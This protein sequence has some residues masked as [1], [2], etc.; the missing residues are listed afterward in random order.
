MS[1]A[2][3]PINLKV[4]GHDELIHGR[5]PGEPV[6]GMRNPKP[7]RVPTVR[8]KKN[9]FNSDLYIHA[10]ILWPALGF[11]EVIAPQANATGG[12]DPTRCIHLLIIC[13]SK[14][15]YPADVARHLRWVPWGER[16]TRHSP[17]AENGGGNAFANGEIGVY[18]PAVSSSKG[19]IDVV[20]FADDLGSGSGIQVGLSKF[21]LNFYKGGY[22]AI[23]GKKVKL[24][25]LHHVKISESASAQL[26]AG[27][28][29]NLFWIN[30]DEKDTANERSA[31]M[32]PLIDK[33]AKNS[34]FGKDGVPTYETFTKGGKEHPYATGLLGEYEYDFR[35]TTDAANRT[36]V[37][38]PL[39]VREAPAEL[40]IGHLTD[41]HYC[42]R[43]D[44]YEHN[45]KRA[46]I[47][48]ATYNEFNNWNRTCNKLYSMAK[49]TNDVLL[50][51]GDLIDY[52]RGVGDFVS[53]DGGA[54][55][56]WDDAYWRDRNWF[57]FYD[58]IANGTN[59]EKPVYTILGNHD[60]RF[61]PYAPSSP[62]APDPEAMNLT[63]K[64]VEI[65]HGPG[66]NAGRM[67]PAEGIDKVFAYLGNKLLPW[68]RNGRLEI[69]GT[70][71]HTVIDSVAW[72]LLLINPFLDYS[73]SIPGGYD[74]LM[75]DW[76]ED[77]N[78]DKPQYNKGVD[79]GRTIVLPNVVGSPNAMKSLSQEQKDIVEHFVEGKGRAKFFGVHAAVVGPWGH[80]Y[81][82][83]LAR[84]VVVLPHN[85]KL[86][87]GRHSP[88]A[89]EGV[90][91]KSGP[92]RFTEHPALAVR[93]K[94]YEPFAQVAN[95]GTMDEKREWLIQ[96]L[97]QAGVQL[98]FSGH[99][100]RRTLLTLE[101][102]SDGALIVQFIDDGEISKAS[103]LPV[104]VNSTSAGPRGQIRPY[105]DGSQLLESAFAEVKL[106]AGGKIVDITHRT[107]SSPST[108]PAT[109]LKKPAPAPP[110]TPAPSPAPMKVPR[111][112]F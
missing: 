47:R 94:D 51:T 98:V 78:V 27:A 90:P 44:R 67:Y 35:R 9:T 16:H 28:L 68:R 86:Q 96:K 24:R 23:N 52:G 105:K 22:K 55:M 14:L 63:K 37:L 109:G 75:L 5:K 97:R 43:M 72:Y 70:P 81:D 85:P 19:L 11:P 91:G 6:L 80:W 84:S 29:Y 8:R 33:F 25:Y 34:R 108:V 88:V 69:E 65:A 10:R 58:A 92:Q 32:H 99:V 41:L 103:A 40:K 89:T 53:E 102:K 42:I 4:P 3:K 31:E 26:P 15:L 106:S 13:E 46:G 83:D 95:D 18:D 93:H 61:H 17:S 66:H 38:H 101:K 1:D 12:H 45:L 56:G 64:Q 77:E 62:G 76:A 79:E 104:F 48:T 2:P 49:Q 7:L 112:T 74:V 87:K 73:F 21:V 111:L 60:W 59:Y 20:R 82:N 107:I 39:F 100:H 54:L 57:L 30:P 36:E 50:L 110:P 71:I